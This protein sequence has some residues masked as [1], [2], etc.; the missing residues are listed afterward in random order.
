MELPGGGL[1]IVLGPNGAGKTTLLRTMHGIERISGGDVRWQ[2]SRREAELHQ[3]FVFQTP[4]IMRRSVLDNIAYP[5]HLRGH[6][7]KASRQQAEDWAQRIGLGD[8]LERPAT[9]LSGGERQKLALARALIIKPDIVFLD[10]PTANLDGSAM[11]DIEQ[12]VQDAHESGMTI[13]LA[14]HNLGQ[15][16]RLGKEVIYI[17][18]GVIQERSSAKAFFAGPEDAGAA[19]F[20]NG[21]IV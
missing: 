13:V 5:L 1:T 17:Q 18:D 12:L 2:V 21:D 6:P 9:V 11:R 19:A 10:E 7:R 4:I 14:T 3:S 20:I 15:A 8:A 16:R